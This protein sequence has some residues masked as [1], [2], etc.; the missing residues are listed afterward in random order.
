MRLT[1]DTRTTRHFIPFLPF[2]FL[3]IVF[4]GHG[5]L[6]ILL[7]LL[8]SV[9]LTAGISF[10][11]LR[12]RARMDSPLAAVFVAPASSAGLQGVLQLDAAGIHWMPR[13]ARLPLWFIPWSDVVRT[14]VREAGETSELHVELAGGDTMTLLVDV[15]AVE[16]ERALAR[17]ASGSPR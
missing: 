1:R 10:L 7:S 16:L 13:R 14:A 11:L 4:G 15:P 9:T 12:R 17:A 2:L 5:P 3:G 8:V 6:P